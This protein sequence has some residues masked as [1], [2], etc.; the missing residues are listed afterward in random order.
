MTPT[1]AAAARAAGSCRQCPVSCE[2]VVYPAGCIESGC[3]RL[4]S[5][6]DEETGRTWM[7]CLE[8]VYRA[9]IDLDG[10]RRLQRT[11]AGFGALRATK[12]P[13]P[14]CRCDVERTFEHRSDGPCVNP[15]FLL[16]GRDR[17]YTVRATRR[18]DDERV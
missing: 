12:E 10:F 9:E 15:D 7:G 18:E 14:M 17:V 4:Y 3:S 13:L 5:Y 1:T 6:E 8:G 2:R 16:S 11:A